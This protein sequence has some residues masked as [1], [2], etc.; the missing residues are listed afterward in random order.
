[1]SL[2]PSFSQDVLANT[3]EKPTPTYVDVASTGY[4][5]VVSQQTSM[6]S[7][8]VPGAERI[9]RAV[10]PRHASVVTELDDT[11]YSDYAAPGKRVIAVFGSARKHYIMYASGSSLHCPVC[12]CDFD[13]LRAGMD[14]YGVSMPVCSAVELKL[15]CDGGGS[16]RAVMVAY[17]PPQRGDIVKPR[18]NPFKAYLEESVAAREA[19]FDLLPQLEPGALNRSIRR[20]G[21]ARDG[22][23]VKIAAIVKEKLAPQYKQRRLSTDDFKRLARQITCDAF[24]ADPDGDPEAA[25]LRAWTKH[26]TPPS[27]S[28]SI[29]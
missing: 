7:Y 23:K 26:R 12:G 22:N 17:K 16:G 8:N 21:K 5:R 6:R 28:A 25:A 4:T 24:E 1:M 9:V 19:R 15:G 14:H 11:A 20:A 3:E 18:I 10:S 13:S 27:R 2:S 29:N